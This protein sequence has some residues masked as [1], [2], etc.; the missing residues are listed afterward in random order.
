MMSCT[1]GLFTGM[2]CSL[3][4][5]C[6]VGCLLF[7]LWCV[8]SKH[9]HADGSYFNRR[10][11][12]FT[13]DGD[14]F[15]RYQSFANGEDLKSAIKA[16]CPAKI[17]IGPVYNVDPQKRAAYAAGNTFAPVERELVFDIDITD[18]DD[19]RTCGKDAHIC[20]TCWPLMAT[21]IDVLDDALRNDF[22]FQ[23][24]FFVFSG[25][26]GVHAWVCD[27]KARKLPDEARA[28]IAQYLSVYKGLEKGVPKLNTGIESHPFISKTYDVLA[29]VF[30]SKVLPGQKLL[31]DKEQT[32]S[33]LQMIP[34][35]VRESA[36]SEWKK[37]NNDDQGDVSV[38]RWK[39]IQECLKKECTRYAKA[40]PRD[41]R[42]VKLMEK[43]VRDVVF[44][45]TYPRL[46][47]EVS[48]K[49]NHLLKAPFCVHPKTGKVCVPIDPKEAW[50]F[51]P[52][53]VC[54]V[55][56]LLNELNSSAA[57]DA[58]DNRSYMNTGMGGAVKTFE[59]CFLNSL[60]RENKEVLAS[61]VR[62]QGA[63]V[64]W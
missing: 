56:E 49:M 10:E 22:G 52:D 13:L 41:V 32:H 8:D 55:G 29:Q 11:F 23:H 9:P 37:L 19:V 6:C 54:T 21:A 3:C 5:S 38:A 50:S 57:G 35:S 48:K 40:N 42:T 15:V 18:Y 59:A 61:R 7:L 24:V 12:C 4:T 17:D 39:V 25:R 30:E 28:A 53:T 63:H 45:Y 46:D 33:I 62:D 44:A 31:E 34:E 20:T 2:V 43:S 14:I 1:S 47:I 60:L 64:S 36:V 51:N 58:N 27:E 16:R 26:R